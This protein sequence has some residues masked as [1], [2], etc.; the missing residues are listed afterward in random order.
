MTAREDPVG[1]GVLQLQ[2]C[3]VVGISV[4][5]TGLVAVGVSFQPVVPSNFLAVQEQ[6]SY[7]RLRAQPVA[8]EDRG[9]PLLAL[10]ESQGGNRQ[11]CSLALSNHAPFECSKGP[12][13]YQ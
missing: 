1:V 9:S 4:I 8:C 12:Q 7:G 3:S 2:S 10:P 6:H 13:G 5:K 11:G